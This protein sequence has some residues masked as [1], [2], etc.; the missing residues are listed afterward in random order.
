MTTSKKRSTSE[1]LNLYE[2]YL[3]SK[4]SKVRILGEAKERDLISVFVELSVSDRHHSTE[5]T[6]LLEKADAAIRL[7]TDP[8]EPGNFDK[9]REP[10]QGGDTKAK[11]NPTNYSKRA[12][13]QSL[14]ERQDVARRRYLNTWHCRHTRQAGL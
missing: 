11:S 9:L 4:V 12:L 3:L 2:A 8:F 5:S 14:S 7:R 6:R 1:V 10:L 13:E